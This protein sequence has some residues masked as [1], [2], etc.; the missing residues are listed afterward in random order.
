[1]YA[2]PGCLSVYGRAGFGYIS[3]KQI[4]PRFD[5]VRKL[6]CEDK[7]S[8]EHRKTISPTQA[9]KNASHNLCS[10]ERLTWFAWQPEHDKK[11]PGGH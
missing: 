5:S 6:A 9:Q 1:M 11:T 4:T 7:N 8:P 2:R 10:N 3:L